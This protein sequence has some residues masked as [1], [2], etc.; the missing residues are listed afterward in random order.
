MKKGFLEK[1][2]LEK[3]AK[4]LKEEYRLE[5]EKKID[6]FVATINKNIEEFNYKI[7]VLVHPKTRVVYFGIIN[8]VDD[9][10]SKLA[11]NFTPNELVYFKK[12]LEN[13]QSLEDEGKDLYLSDATNLREKSMSL[14]IA[15]QCLANLIQEGW[16]E[17]NKNKIQIGVRSFLDLRSF[18]EQNQDQ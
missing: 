6:D 4:E 3:K 9:E 15:D 12:I 1:I 5:I 11:T 2:E 13:I 7:Q 10:I 16:L 14:D 8:E 18:L 17:K